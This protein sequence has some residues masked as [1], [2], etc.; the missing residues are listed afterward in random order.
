MK[1]EL[2]HEKNQ[3]PLYNSGVALKDEQVAKY[4][5]HIL[6]LNSR[7]ATLTEINDDLK[8]DLELMKKDQ[9]ENYY[10]VDN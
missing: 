5:E 2:E 7:V 10:W 8:R 6:F 1:S 4:E 9:D 3:I